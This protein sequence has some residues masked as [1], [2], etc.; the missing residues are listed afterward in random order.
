MKTII[1]PNNK[2]DRYMSSP[3]VMD[4]GTFE[5]KTLRST[6]N[7]IDRIFIVPEDCEIRYYKDNKPVLLKAEKGDLVM[8]FFKKEYLK[9]Y[10][11]VIKNKELKENIKACE[12]SMAMNQLK[13]ESLCSDCCDCC[14]SICRDC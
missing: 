8:S 11:I 2:D 6:S 14:E 12:L 9:H 3:I 5:V 13:K 4:L 1:F 7:G 10:V